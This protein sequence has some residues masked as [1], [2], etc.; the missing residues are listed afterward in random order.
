LDRLKPLAE[1]LGLYLAGGAAIALHL[2]HR[3]SRDLDLFSRTP[4][5]DLEQ[6]R[7]TL[8]VVPN[9]EI[10]S[11]TDAALRLRLD[12]VPVDIVRYPYA[13]LDQTWQGPGGF[14][15]ASLEDLTTMKLSAVARRGIRR[16]FWDLYAIFHGAS[17]TLERALADYT[18]RYGVKESDLYHVL[19]ALTYFDDA[20]ADPLLPDGMTPAQWTEIKAW[21]TEHV[22]IVM[23]AVLG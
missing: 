4:A 13:P 6:V 14:P 5:L 1:S 3:V 15:I 16:D 11:M 18:R 8:A 20:D 9:T 10:I 17:L 2:G 22:P 19:R 12:G 23:R 7:A 21:F